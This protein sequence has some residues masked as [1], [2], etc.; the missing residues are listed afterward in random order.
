MRNL[1]HVFRLVRPARPFTQSV[2][3]AD[4]KLLTEQLIH[5]AVLCRSTGKCSEFEQRIENMALRDRHSRK[6]HLFR[7]GDV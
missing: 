5:N 4:S 7:Q 3:S 2:A 6:I 1:E